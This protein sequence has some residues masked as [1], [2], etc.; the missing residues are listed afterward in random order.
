M[1]ARMSSLIEGLVSCHVTS[2]VIERLGMN[3]AAS[4]A[5]MNSRRQGRS[6]GSFLPMAVAAWF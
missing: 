6:S 3:A 2:K 5:S 4:F 1:C